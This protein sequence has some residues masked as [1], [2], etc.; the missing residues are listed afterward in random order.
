MKTVV[1]FVA[2]LGL[3]LSLVIR[4]TFNSVRN[5]L[6][7]LSTDPDRAESLKPIGHKHK[8]QQLVGGYS[9]I[10]DVKNLDESVK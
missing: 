2:L 1:L 9:A 5:P 8:Q 4:K 3:S 7:N 10:K 6:S